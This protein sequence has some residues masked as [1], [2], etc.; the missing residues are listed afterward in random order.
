VGDDAQ[1]HALLEVEDLY[2]DRPLRVGEEDF[3]RRVVAVQ[4]AAFAHPDFADDSSDHALQ[5]NVREII[6]GI[7]I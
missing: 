5:S 1:R 6:Y 4:L 3:H 2:L 7:K